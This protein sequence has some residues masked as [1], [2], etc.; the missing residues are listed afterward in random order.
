MHTIDHL[1]ARFGLFSVVLFTCFFVMF[2]ADTY[3]C[4]ILGPRLSLFWIS[5]D[6]SS[7]FQSQSGFCLICFC[8]GEC[9][10]HVFPEIHLWCYTCRPCFYNLLDFSE[11]KKGHRTNDN[12][13]STPRNVEKKIEFIQHLRLQMI[14]NSCKRCKENIAQCPTPRDEEEVTTYLTSSHICT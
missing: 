13:S 8:G 6:V 7:G 2:L 11:K 9:N 5:G 4:I 3:T 10:V 12:I 14:K 1:H